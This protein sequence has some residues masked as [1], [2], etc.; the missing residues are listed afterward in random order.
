M[1]SDI[2]AECGTPLMYGFRTSLNLLGDPSLNPDT[3][4]IGMTIHRQSGEPLHFTR[5]RGVKCAVSE[6][7]DLYVV[8]TAHEPCDLGQGEHRYEV[9]AV[10]ELGEVVLRETGVMSVVLLDESALEQNANT[11]PGTDFDYFRRIVTYTRDDF[12]DPEVPDEVYASR[13]SECESCPLLNADKVC[14]DCGCFM[15]MKA[16]LVVAECPLGKW[17]AHVEGS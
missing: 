12:P 14:M 3:L 9:T 2:A 8:C 15:P 7:G 16:G 17:G 1:S 10:T 4:D 5:D 13:L 6:T 11:F